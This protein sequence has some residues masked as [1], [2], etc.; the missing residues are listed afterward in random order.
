MQ[1][2][3]PRDTHIIPAFFSRALNLPTTPAPLEQVW[4]AKHVGVDVR[5]GVWGATKMLR[6]GSA[7]F[8]VVIDVCSV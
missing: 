3:T 4:S 6:G 5:L 2:L 8:R 7:K 1:P